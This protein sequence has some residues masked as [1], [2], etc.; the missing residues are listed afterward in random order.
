MFVVAIILFFAEISSAQ[1]ILLKPDQDETISNL[2]PQIRSFMELPVKERR[3]AFNNPKDRLQIS[4]AR[5][6]VP[7]RFTW[8]NISGD[9]GAFKL[10]ISTKPDFSTPSQALVL[11]T[12]KKGRE[13]GADVTNFE[14]GKTFYWKVML[15]TKD[16]KQIF[17]QIRKFQ[18]DPF[19]MRLIDLPDVTNTRDIGGKPGL[20]GRMIR[21]GMVYRSSGL[22]EDSP[23]FKDDDKSTWNPPNREDFRI[24]KPRI[25]PAGAEY[26]R[27]V[28]KWRTELD[29][30]TNGEVGAMKGSPV[31]PKLNWIHQSSP[32]YEGIFEKRWA[33]VMAEDFKVF[34][35]TTNYPI[36][37]HCISGEDRTGSLAIIIEGVLGV[38]ADELEKDWEISAQSDLNY[39]NEFTPL[40]NG[41]NNFGHAKTPL[42][43]KIENYL[44]SIGITEDEI[45]KFR[46]IMLENR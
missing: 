40:M 9:S 29:L 14:I 20:D 19:P 35:D 18:T 31:G 3:K 1:I 8:K 42:V 34:L 23:D 7:Y 32:A 21:Q 37:F 26:V 36:D 45:D 41:F 24:G 2:P 4:N 38:G 43:K 33:K 13:N 16:G 44:H 5:S 17:S 15:T 28:L 46:S 27:D 6:G 25:T 12:W 39:R 10:E 30:R 11:K 22:N